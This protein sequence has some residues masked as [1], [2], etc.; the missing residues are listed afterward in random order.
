MGP[1]KAN[2]RQN[3]RTLLLDDE[4]HGFAPPLFQE[5]F[6]PVLEGINGLRIKVANGVEGSPLLVYH[7][8]FA[9]ELSEQLLQTTEFIV[10]ANREADCRRIVG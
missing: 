5:D 9:L 7:L 8:E 6:P 4:L 2:I 3:F 10:Y 1:D